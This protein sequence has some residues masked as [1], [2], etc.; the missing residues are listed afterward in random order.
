MHVRYQASCV[1]DKPHA[2]RQQVSLGRKAERQRLDPIDFPP[3]RARFRMRPPL[4]LVGAVL[5]CGWLRGG[6]P[7]LCWSALRARRPSQMRRSL[8][9]RRTASGS[10]SQNAPWVRHPPCSMLGRSVAHLAGSAMISRG[11]IAAHHHRMSPIFPRSKAFL[12][13]EP[14][15]VEA[16]PSLENRRE[17]LAKKKC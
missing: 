4:L 12:K 13:S 5:R 9:G 15:A 2:W 14:Q 16:S 17:A 6:R 11:S 1:L 10:S 7:S 8:P 3:P